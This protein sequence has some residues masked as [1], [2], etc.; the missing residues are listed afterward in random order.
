MYKR[1]GKRA[2]QGWE[3]MEHFNVTSRSYQGPLTLY[4]FQIINLQ[5]I[6]PLCEEGCYA[7]IA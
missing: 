2:E 7:S 1:V 4:S 5:H 6:K 3:E